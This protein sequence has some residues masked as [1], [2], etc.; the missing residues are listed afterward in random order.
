MR[1]ALHTY[2]LTEWESGQW[3]D[4]GRVGDRF[5]RVLEQ[6]VIHQLRE[7]DWRKYAGVEIVDWDTGVVLQTVR[8]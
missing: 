3:H 4:A 5:R 2:Q 8:R 6:D 7:G 1:R